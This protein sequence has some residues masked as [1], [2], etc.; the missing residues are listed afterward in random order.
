[1]PPMSEFYSQLSSGSLPL[2]ILICVIFPPGK[3][4]LENPAFGKLFPSSKKLPPQDLQTLED[5]LCFIVSVL[6]LRNI[7]ELLLV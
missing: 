4:P 2:E 5:L 7:F 1:M 6:T 3:S